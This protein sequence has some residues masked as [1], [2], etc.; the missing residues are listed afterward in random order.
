ML[1]RHPSN[2]IAL[3]Q[4]LLGILLVTGCAQFRLPAIDP[5]G[6]QIFLPGENYT[7]LVAPALVPG[8]P[9]PA[10]QNPPPVPACG[11]APPPAPIVPWARQASCPRGCGIAGPS[12]GA[13]Q[14]SC[15]VAEPSCG[16]ADPS[17]GVAEPSCGVVA[18]P[19]PMAPPAPP[20]V[21]APP[22]PPEG[23]IL[24][25]PH[26]IMAP[27]GS[28]VILVS[29]LVGKRGEYEPRTP[30]EWTIAPDSVGHLLTTSAD[31]QCTT[32]VFHH[33][34]HRRSGSQAVT[35]SSTSPQVLTRGTPTPADDV[36]ILRG[37]GWVTVMSPSEGTTHVTVLAPK[38]KNWDQR[39]QTATIY[40][41]DVQWTLPAPA[42][43]QASQPHVL[44]T[45]VH[46]S[47]GK[48]Q[49]G[50]IVRYEILQPGATFGSDG[51]TSVEVPTDE[52]GRASVNLAP[53]NRSQAAQVEIKIIRPSDPNDDLPRMVVG[54]GFTTVTWSAPDPKVTLYGPETAQV[55]GTA[56][57][58]ADIANVGDILARDLT[59]STTIPAN[60]TFVQSD[61]PA[62]VM[63]DRLV[64]NLGNLAPTEWRSLTIHL[65]P[66]RNGDARFCVRVSS[67]DRV[68]DQP[69]QAE[70]CV[71]TR[72]FS[73]ALAVRLSGPATAQVGE[74]IPF[75]IEVTNT[76]T[77]PLVNVL[78][79]NRLPAGLELPGQA[80]SLIERALTQPLQAG[81]SQT[82]ELPLIVRQSGRLCQ[83][84]EVFATGGHTATA[85]SCIEVTQPSAPTGPSVPS[86]PSVPA[87]PSVPSVPSGPS[88]PSDPSAPPPQARVQVDI[89][90]PLQAR[91]GQLVSYQMSITN[92]G[93]VPLTGVR[94][95]NTYEPSLYP[96]E[97]SKG[98]D[99][100]ALRRGELVW[101]VDRI[102]PGET[103]QRESKYEC[104]R[105]STAAWSRVFVE[106]AEQI[107]ATRETTTQI[108]PSETPPRRPGT[109]P[110][111]D[112]G[113]QP[114]PEEVTG[115]LRV[116]IADTRDPIAV[117][118]T[119]TYIIGIE[120]ARNVSDRNV[121]LTILLP[122]GMEY[123][124]LNGPVVARRLS[125]DKR[126]IEVTPIAEV[127]PGETLNPF[128]LEARG[129]RIGKHTVKVRVD[130]FRSTQP[131]EAETDTS[132][133]VS[134]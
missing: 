114:K 11:T 102:E 46:R 128:Y 82:I 54:R 42:I 1:R 121:T 50:W 15:G 43:V 3:G 92:Q 32:Q 103:V 75:A 127:R 30:I 123:V 36:S 29:G 105:E 134:G 17:C 49:P 112:S 8:M 107:R 22:P 122:P 41:V 97:A 76:G 70:A 79:R 23:R 31:G 16:I 48:P 85:S 4:A 47:S 27:V 119:T 129:T 34:S 116:S 86:G 55:G 91:V 126:T 24:V 99:Q 2:L 60:M 120:N 124:K 59:A 104:L 108:L 10:Y 57:Y 13:C 67:G 78:I 28:E 117:N 111:A 101:T 64:W 35:W 56:S 73:S 52:A 69:L 133:N 7:T 9:E 6:Q 38:A 71:Q 58:R 131:I 66:E 100:N 89:Q 44:T 37:Q 98:F 88:T 25:A 18:P 39:R 5:T 93:G 62:Q 19:A 72:V 21:V 26:R 95:V 90:G 65:R 125:D 12:C 110:D 118:S 94:I 80:G 68:Q 106:S 81:L 96:K 132:V 109:V 51:Q 115:N 33:A 14:P 45:L 130:S 61:P 40:W 53:V 20:V 77:E 83:V 63:G 74:Q 84:V 113:A 87:G